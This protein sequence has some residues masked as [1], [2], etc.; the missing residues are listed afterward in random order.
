[1]S[2]LLTVASVAVAVLVGYVAGFF[3]RRAAQR[4]EVKK[5]KEEILALVDEVAKNKT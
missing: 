5:A 4:A 1:M 2:G 3:H